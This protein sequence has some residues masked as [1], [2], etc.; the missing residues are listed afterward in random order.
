MRKAS[1][2]TVLGVLPERG[3]RGLPLEELYRKLFN[4]QLYLAYG[5]IYASEGAVTPGPPGR[6]RTA[7]R[8]AR[9]GASSMRCATSVTGSAWSSGF[10][11]RRR[12][13]DCGRSARPAALVKQAGR[14]G[15]APAA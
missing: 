7:C 13:A 4:P 6:P 2:G 8:W 9:S 15:G 10:T 5:R 14:R 11:S 3:R 12:A 1:A